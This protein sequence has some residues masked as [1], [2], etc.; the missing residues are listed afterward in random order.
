MAMAHAVFGLEPIHDLHVLH[1]G[2][3][4]HQAQP[5]LNREPVL[6]LNRWEI[7]RR[8]G[9]FLRCSHGALDFASENLGQHGSVNSLSFSQ[10]TENRPTRR[11]QK[12]P[13]T[14]K[15]FF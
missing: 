3:L 7:G 8:A 13:K 10:S 11:L 15:I 9:D 2:L 4:P 14:A 6:L 1:A 5:M 12:K